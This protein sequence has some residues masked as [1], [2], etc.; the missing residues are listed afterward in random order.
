MLAGGPEVTCQSLAYII[1]GQKGDIWT[2]M[3]AVQSL[4]V[5][6]GKRKGEVKGKKKK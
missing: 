4:E 5:L 3:N 6:R 2:E 1:I